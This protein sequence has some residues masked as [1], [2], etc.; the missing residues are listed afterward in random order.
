MR[1]HI[2]TLFLT[3]FVV[4]A[5]GPLASCSSGTQSPSTPNS[6]GSVAPSGGTKGT[7]GP[8]TGGAGSGGT[9][10]SG[11]QS[12]ARGGST[13]IANA[14]G[15]A[16][17]TGGST[18]ASGG[19]TSNGGTAGK[20]S[21]VDGGQAGSTGGTPVYDT[22]VTT[23]G[24]TNAS[25]GGSATSGT[26]ATGSAATT[27][28]NATGGTKSTGGTTPTGGGGIGGRT[29]TGGGGI[30]GTTSAGGGGTSGTTS[31]GGGGT[32]GTTSTDSCPVGLVGWATVEGDGL[33]TTT[34]GGNTTP[35]RVTTLSDFMSLA[36]DSTA[37]VIEISGTIDTGTSPVD[38]ASNKTV[39]GVNKSATIKGGINIREGSSNI[40]VRNLTIQGKGQG[41]DPVDTVA[42]RGS[43]HL[44][45]DHLSISDASD[46]NLDLTKGSNYLTVSWSRFSY[47]DPNHTHR[48]SCLVGAGS[49]EAATDT[50]KNNVTY[51]HNW[52]AELVDQRMPRVLFGKGHV[53]N[54]YYTSS[55]NGYCVG[56][57]SYASVLVEGNYFKN[58]K[59]PHRFQDTNPSYI[60]ARDNVYDNT[61]GTRDTGLGGNGGSV[62][63]FTDPPYDYALDATANIPDLV[64]RCAGP[65]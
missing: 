63:P 64:T 41:N 14:S 9:L 39:V 31:A 2:P 18:A 28:G 26:K 12:S 49:T 4:S 1:Q 65:R 32:S 10:A 48:L 40:I 43:H 30:G 19:V 57:G 46:G 56:T 58:V 15:G 38:I 11:G 29:P 33:N 24:T 59:D 35:Q 34:G 54:S 6:G 62:T 42:A 23:G 20:G 36:G 5:I 25:G 22:A 7:G 17:A 3:L 44:W 45:F 47:T 53:F 37:R 51:H 60:T 61:T 21:V 8:A 27:G 52:F 55:G 50:G 13:A 16:P